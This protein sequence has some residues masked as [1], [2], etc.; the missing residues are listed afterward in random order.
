MVGHPPMNPACCGETHEWMWWLRQQVEMTMPDIKGDQTAAAMRRT[1]REMA[2]SW[3]RHCPIASTQ[4]G[5]KKSSKDQAQGG[6][7]TGVL[8]G[9][10]PH[11]LKSGHHR[12]TI[13]RRDGLVWVHGKQHGTDKRVDFIPR[14]PHLPAHTPPSTAALLQREV[15]RLPHKYCGGQ[16]IRGAWQLPWCSALQIPL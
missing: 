10:W 13:E 14:K 12:I 4:R 2:A 7:S 6:R 3:A 5:R 8:C 15:A 16:R 1:R 11:I 9:P